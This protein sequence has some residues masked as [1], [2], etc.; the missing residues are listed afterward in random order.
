MAIPEPS[1]ASLPMFNLAPLPGYLAADYTIR[2][3]PV[4]QMGTHW[5]DHTMPEL[6]PTLQ[7]FTH[8]LIYGSYNGKVAFLE[9]M[10]TRDFLLGS[11]EVHK[12]IKQ[13]LYYDQPGKYYPSRYNIYTSAQKIYFTLDQFVLR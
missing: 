5:L 11:T 10:V 7:P 3:E 8:V 6:P 4:A 12:A 1:P 9:P 13:P 2:G